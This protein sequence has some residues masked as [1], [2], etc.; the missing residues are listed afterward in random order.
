[1][2]PKILVEYHVKWKNAL[3]KDVELGASAAFRSEGRPIPLG[4]PVNPLISWRLAAIAFSSQQP[5]LTSD[6]SKLVCQ[7]GQCWRARCA[8]S[9]R[10]TPTAFRFGMDDPCVAYRSQRRVTHQLDPPIMANDR[11]RRFCRG[12]SRTLPVDDSSRTAVRGG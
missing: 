3:A 8:E 11:P 4:F 2:S 1:M 12:F 5:E 10:D 9:Q 6:A 7:S